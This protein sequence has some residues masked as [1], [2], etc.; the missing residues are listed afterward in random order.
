M[1]SGSYC[2]KLS[3]PEQIVQFI[4]GKSFP[5][6]GSFALQLIDFKRKIDGPDLLKYWHGSCI[7][8]RATDPLEINQSSPAGDI[9]AGDEK[10][11]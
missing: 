3:L 11:E 6:P 9:L 1:M 4:A 7:I 2:Q 5:S 8:V 10:E